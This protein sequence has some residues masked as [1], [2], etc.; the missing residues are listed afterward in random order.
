MLVVELCTIESETYFVVPSLHIHVLERSS[1]QASR[2][3]ESPELNG[4]LNCYNEVSVMAF[5]NKVIGK[6]DW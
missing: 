4:A 1:S 6:G 3:K 5:Q 2:E